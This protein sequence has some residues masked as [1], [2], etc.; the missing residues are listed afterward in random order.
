MYSLIVHRAL[1][2]FK[3]EAIFVV[4]A[5][6]ATHLKKSMTHSYITSLMSKSCIQSSRIHSQFISW[7]TQHSYSKVSGTKADC[8]LLW[9]IPQSFIQTESS[10]HTVLLYLTCSC[11]RYPHHNC[12]FFLSAPK[13]ERLDD[14]SCE[15][16]WEA[17]SPMKGDPIIYTLQ[18]MMGNS[19][20]KQVY[21]LLW[22]DT[23][24]QWLLYADQGSKW[25]CMCTKNPEITCSNCT[26]CSG[27]T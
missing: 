1:W 5:Y 18:C 16:T 13:V 2:H 17:L 6:N 10:L 9:T 24:S 22:E 21:T 12:T 27:S 8:F 14:N 4:Y 11:C 19:D 20:F 26:P 7:V 3:Q 23:L 25:K 15:V